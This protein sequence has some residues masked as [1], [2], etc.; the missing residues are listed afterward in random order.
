MF[1]W[2]ATH[3][4]EH[5]FEAILTIWTVIY[6]CS[7]ILFSYWTERAYVVFGRSDGVIVQFLKGDVGL[8]VFYTNTG[9]TP[10]VDVV[11]ELWLIPEK[12]IAPIRERAVSINHRMIA[13]GYPEEAIL[14]MPGGTAETLKVKQGEASV[15]VLARVYYTDVFHFVH[16]VEVAADYYSEP[17]NRFQSAGIMH[18]CDPQ[19][20]SV[21]YNRVCVPT[22]DKKSGAW[23]AT[24]EAFNVEKPDS[25]SPVN[26]PAPCLPKPTATPTATPTPKPKHKYRYHEV[27]SYFSHFPSPSYG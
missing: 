10:A 21:R 2:I 11:T 19:I 1:N 27:D 8:E 20:K 6:A 13:A 15:G 4:R 12:L 3:F 23:I 25:T 26:D 5:P 16:C 14:F 22:A 24:W 7:F 17:L 18:I 9:R